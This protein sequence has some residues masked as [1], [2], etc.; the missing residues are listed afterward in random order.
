MK[1]PL[2]IRFNIS[3]I[4]VHIVN[5]EFE[6]LNQMLPCHSHSKNSYEIHYVPLGSGSVRINNESFEVTPN[7]LYVTGPMVEHEQISD[8]KNPMY[9]YCIY[10]ELD[11]IPGMPINKSEAAFIDAFKV[12]KSWFGKDTQNIYALFQKLFAELEH[13]FTGYTIQVEALLKQIIVSLVRNYSKNL[14]DKSL[15]LS[16]NIND[17]KY[18][19]IEK[20]FLFEYSD[21]T[22]Q[23]LSNRLSLSPRQTERLL[24]SHYGMTFSKK[25][26]E[27]KMNTAT[28]LLR[29]GNM[30][31]SQIAQ[32]LGYSSVEHFSTSFRR[33]YGKSPRNYMKDIVSEKNIL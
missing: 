19:I 16:S 14:P 28:Y 4:C 31:I 30:N 11:T 1:T 33:Y 8:K 2:N 18:L 29:E 17:S 27:S 25:R 9:E 24:M 20:C 26:L 6:L 10:L 23:T 3:N 21:L 15:I 12:Q 5:I 7:T 32:K 13:K 22:L